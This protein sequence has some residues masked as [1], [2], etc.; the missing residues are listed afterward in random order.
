MN[1]K[2]LAKACVEAAMELARCSGEEGFEVVGAVAFDVP[3]EEGLLYGVLAG[4]GTQAF[5]LTLLRGD[6]ALAALDELVTTMNH[7]VLKGNEVSFLT[8]GLIRMK[9]LAPGF[10]GI[11]QRAEYPPSRLAPAIAAKVAHEPIRP[12]N[13]AVSSAMFRSSA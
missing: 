6:D 13:R 10:L 1:A 2:R 9:E 8:M 7:G 5:S 3:S 4:H 11:L 12:P